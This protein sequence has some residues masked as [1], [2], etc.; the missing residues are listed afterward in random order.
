MSLFILVAA[1][2]ALSAQ[3]FELPPVTLPNVPSRAATPGAFLPN[4]W[5]VEQQAAGDL[6]GDGVEDAALIMRAL[7]PA[8]LVEHDGFGM[9]PYDTNPLMLV[10][11]FGRPEGGYDLALADH[12]LIPRPD[13]PVMADV[14]GEAPPM[15]IAR[16]ALKVSLHAWA[17]AGSWS[18]S[19]TAYTLRWRD[20]AFR[21][22]GFDDLNI[23]RGTGEL[24]ERSINYLTGRMSVG[25]GSISSDE[26]ETTWEAAPAGP[27]LTL[28]EIGNGLE[29]DPETR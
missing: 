22:I 15:E 26:V 12:G 17:S 9:S 8:N 28:E 24:V 19:N 5:G 18:M 29:F 10:V 23:H 4:G 21:L 25:V 2:G 7:D 14:V 1:V 6:N 20:G 11:G 13:N 27:L 3:D 16:G